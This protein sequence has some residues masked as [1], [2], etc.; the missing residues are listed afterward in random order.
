LP[1]PRRIARFNRRFTNRLFLKVAGYLPGFAIVNHVGRKSG[2]T[3]RTPINAF[4]TDSGYIIA[5][6]YG[7]ESDWVKN[8][9]AAGSCEL[10][11]RRRRVRLFDPRINTDRNKGW[12][13]LPVKLILDFIDAPEYMQLSLEHAEAHTSEKALKPVSTS[14]QE[15]GSAMVELPS[16]PLGDIDPEFEKIAL[17]TG[18]LTY[19]LP[20][21]STREKLLL[22][23]ANDVCREHFGLAFRL[24]VQAALSHGV[25]F[26]DILGVV[27]F[28][29]PYAGYPAAA[30]A[31]ERLGDIAAELGVDVRSVAAEAGVD[32]SSGTPDQHWR[33]DEGFDTTDEWLADFITSRTARSWAVPG[34]STRER[35][36]L[37]LTADVAQQTL[38]D[39]FRLHVRLARESGAIPEEIRDVVRFLAE[40]GIAKAAAALC[41]LD[42]VLDAG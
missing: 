37:A 39:S 41:E 26:S 8:V 28:I 40:C 9:L 24:H 42:T 33:P 10:Q 18:G 29:G 35:A 1:A 23:L 2:R 13:P 32:G 20:G 27:R 4:R 21:T 22:N 31:L 38:G 15:K 14:L 36:Y 11:T 16:Q 25:P 30:D 3:Y 5:L 12:A 19:S 6:T 7:S 17:E 34:L